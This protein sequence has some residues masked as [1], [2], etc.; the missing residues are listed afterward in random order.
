MG[1]HYEGKKALANIIRMHKTVHQHSTIEDP[2]YT[3]ALTVPTCG[4]PI[5]EPDRSLINSGIRSFARNCSHMIAFLD[6]DE[7][8]D[9]S[10]DERRSV[11]WSSDK[12]H[13]SDIGY[14][15]LG[16]VRSLT[17]HFAPNNKVASLPGDFQDYCSLHKAQR[18]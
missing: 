18:G 5:S 4:W 13:L 1:T 17:L 2:V 6:A 3:I 10:K 8:L 14:D 9:I 16:K 12:V 11:Y 15:E 7:L